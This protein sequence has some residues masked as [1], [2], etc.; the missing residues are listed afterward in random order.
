M[1]EKNERQ[2]TDHELRKNGSGYNDPTAYRAFKAIEQERYKKFLGCVYRM[3]E[4]SDFYI[5]DIVVKDKR[6]GKVWY[7]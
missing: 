7:K 5:E 4:L 6:T 1:L 2:I 3:G